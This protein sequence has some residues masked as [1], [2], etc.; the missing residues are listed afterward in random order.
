MPSPNSTKASLHRD[1]KLH[2]AEVKGP[3][4]DKLKA[5]RLTV[6]EPPAVRCFIQRGMAPS[7]SFS[8]ELAEA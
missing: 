7:T 6:Q 8:F 5:Q 2:L 3:L 1:I 4:M